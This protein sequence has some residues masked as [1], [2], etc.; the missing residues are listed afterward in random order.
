LLFFSK[1]GKG[2]CQ[3]FI[4]QEKEKKT[5]LQNYKDEP[6]L[7]TTLTRGPATLLYQK[8]LFTCVL[9]G[10]VR[11]SRMPLLIQLRTC[12]LL[13]YHISKVFKKIEISLSMLGLGMGPTF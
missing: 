11:P 3:I 8:L 5:I 2:F 10:T 1:S 6:I 4:R 12:V 7:A 9:L 13:S